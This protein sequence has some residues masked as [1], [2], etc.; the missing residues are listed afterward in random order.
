MVSEELGHALKIY[1]NSLQME[2]IWLN[3]ILLCLYKCSNNNI[4]IT[5]PTTT[6][7]LPTTSKK[8]EEIIF[9]CC[10]FKSAVE[11]CVHSHIH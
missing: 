5:P 7:L 10:N 2:I 8:E 4:N 3:K 9:R 6:S 11:I 1:W